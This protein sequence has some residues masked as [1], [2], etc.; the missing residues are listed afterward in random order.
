[1][2]FQHLSVCARSSEVQLPLVTSFITCHD[3]TH[4]LTEFLAQYIVSLN[5]NDI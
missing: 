4:L 5:D 1:M 2:H 3:M